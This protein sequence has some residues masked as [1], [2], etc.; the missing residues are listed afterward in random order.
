M[1][2]AGCRFALADDRRLAMTSMRVEKRTDMNQA[3]LPAGAAA[4]ELL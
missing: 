1:A 3:T 4:F 2:I